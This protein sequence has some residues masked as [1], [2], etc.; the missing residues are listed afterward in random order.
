MLNRSL[1]GSTRLYD[2]G[3]CLTLLSYLAPYMFNKVMHGFWLCMSCQCVTC[4]WV[5]IKKISLFA[6]SD[7]VDVSLHDALVAEAG[8]T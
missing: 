2:W 8:R 5:S 1:S 4:F 3:S 6:Y 7:A